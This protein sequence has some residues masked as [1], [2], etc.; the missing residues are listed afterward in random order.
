M[1]YLS[2]KFWWFTL[3]NVGPKIHLRDQLQV[4]KRGHQSLPVFQHWPDKYQK[5]FSDHNGSP[6]FNLL[7]NLT[8][9]LYRIL[10]SSDMFYHFFVRISCLTITIEC[11][12]ENENKGR[13]KK[14]KYN[15][16][17]KYILHLNKPKSSFVWHNIFLYIINL[18]TNRGYHT[19]L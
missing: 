7:L 12:Y 2:C 1:F 6:I 15:I 16:F 11:L 8:F 18:S 19:N 3:F 13:I 4:Q 9:F 17:Y 10:E 5:S 14:V